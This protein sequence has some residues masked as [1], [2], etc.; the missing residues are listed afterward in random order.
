MSGRKIDKND[1]NEEIIDYRFND[2]ANSQLL[3]AQKRSGSIGVN[4]D[5]NRNPMREFRLKLQ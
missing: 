3:R 5:H 4:G 1:P 2:H